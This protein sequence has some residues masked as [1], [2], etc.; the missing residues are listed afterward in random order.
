MTPKTT[1]A[2]ALAALLFGFGA[3]AEAQA[4]T[5]F[6]I[7]QSQ[8]VFTWTA[9]AGGM[10]VNGVPNNNFALSGTAE[11]DLY[12]TQPVQSAQLTGSD[13]LVVPDI[14][15]QIPPALPFLPPSLTLLVSN[16]RLSTTSDLFVV[17]AG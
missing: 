11:A 4:P 2:L 14:Q 12:G 1:S 3:S 10:T 8:S 9:D 6:T 13:A 5:Q 15:G 7:D 17:G 16:L